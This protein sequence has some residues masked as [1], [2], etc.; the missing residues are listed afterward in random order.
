MSQIH[1]AQSDEDIRRCFPVMAELRP[2][3]VEGEFVERV[4]RQQAESGYRL[5]CLEDGG[6]VQAVAG[7]RIAEFLAW[8]RIL[9]VDDLVTT[10]HTRSRGHGQKLFDWL[11]THAREN[12]CA[13]FHLD[14]GVQRF[15]AHRFYLR[16]R[17]EIRAH[18][19][20]IPLP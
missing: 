11:L 13:E 18:H 19:F 12:G 14:S 10:A 16:N 1:Q 3:L 6:A 8:G 15:G 2:H 17:Q 4:R 20:S 9:Y 7:F 5:A